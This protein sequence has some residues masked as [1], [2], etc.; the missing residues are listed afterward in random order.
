[1][2]R[3]PRMMAASWAWL[4]WVTVS[5]VT[6]AGLPR[7]LFLHL[8]AAG[9]LDGLGGVGEGQPGRDGGD[10]Q[11][12]LFGAA[13]PVFSLGMGHQHITP[14]QGGELG[15]QAGRGRDLQGFEDPA[16]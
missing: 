3:W 4:A 8:A 14:G 15:V 2:P 11:G 7:P 12:A 6:V 13:V 1:M 5:E 10:L 16:G 9:D